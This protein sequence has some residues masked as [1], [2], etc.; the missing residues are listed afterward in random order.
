L[1]RKGAERETATALSALL[2]V[3]GPG[4]LVERVL[5]VAG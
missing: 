5:V 3:A 1:H 4:L 2:L